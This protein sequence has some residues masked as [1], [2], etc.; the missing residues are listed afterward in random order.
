MNY[1]FGTLPPLS[2]KIEE[3]LEPQEFYKSINWVKAILDWDRGYNYDLAEMLAW[4]YPQAPK[5][6]HPVIIDIVIG[7]RKANKRGQSK[8]E[9]KPSERLQIALDLERQIQSSKYSGRGVGLE[10]LENFLIDRGR[11]NIESV[12]LHHGYDGLTKQYQEHFADRYK[13]S[14]NTIKKYTKELNSLKKNWPNI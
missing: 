14:T 9:L 11:K 12:Q 4:G 7:I 3:P 13:L 10:H 2:A 6:L 8:T 5:S 1:K